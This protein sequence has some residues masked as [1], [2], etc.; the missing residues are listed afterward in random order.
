MAVVLAQQPLGRSR[1][2][3]NAART[4]GRYSPRFRRQRSARFCR[5]NS[6]TPSSCSSRDL[7]ADRGLRLLDVDHHIVLQGVAVALQEDV[8]RGQAG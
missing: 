4:P 6:L 7:M 1:R 8:V 3:L 5:M 2:S